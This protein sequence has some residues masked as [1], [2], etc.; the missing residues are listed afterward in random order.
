MVAD[1]GCWARAFTKSVTQ[2]RLWHVVA[3][4]MVILLLGALPIRG[5]MPRVVAQSTAGTALVHQTGFSAALHEG[6]CADLGA[7]AA[8]ITYASVPLGPP[9]GNPDAQP[10]ASS[11]TTVPLPLERL[12]A[13]DHI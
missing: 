3:T 13:S 11:F 1:P 5:T 9:V 7:L 4:M 8:P 12:R 2:R 10:V 6:D